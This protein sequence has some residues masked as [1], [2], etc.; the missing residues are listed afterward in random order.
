MLCIYSQQVRETRRQVQ[1]S[2]S[3]VQKMSV[4]HQI[5][6]KSHTIGKSY[7]S[8]TNEEMETHEFVNMD[9]GIVCV[10]VLCHAVCGKI[11]VMEHTGGN[12][13]KGSSSIFTS[14]QRVLFLHTP[15]S[16]SKAYYKNA[17][18]IAVV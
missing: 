7:N 10:C 15:P 12:T 4:G 18:L 2:V 17:D 13:S 9:E 8:K 3:G 14:V 5:G 16:Y 11:D 6:D 1:D